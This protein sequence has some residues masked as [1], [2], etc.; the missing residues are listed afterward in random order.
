MSANCFI[1]RCSAKPDMYIYLAEQDDFDCIDKSVKKSLG[2]L[3]FAMELNLSKTTKLAKEN[4]EKVLENL[5]K[6]K[7]H[8]QL[9]PKLSVE[10][11]IAKLNK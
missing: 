1:Y 8:I 6:H 5:A 2:I 3:T 9:P 7:F 4:P 11:L 10:E